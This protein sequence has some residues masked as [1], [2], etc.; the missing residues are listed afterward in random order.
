MGAP[1]IYSVVT[2]MVSVPYTRFGVN[3]CVQYTKKSVDVS[4]SQ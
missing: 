4:K 1:Q 3:F 2:A